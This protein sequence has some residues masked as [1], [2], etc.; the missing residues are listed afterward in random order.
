MRA[1][2]EIGDASNKRFRSDSRTSIWESAVWRR[3]SVFPEFRNFW[4]AKEIRTAGRDKMDN[5]AKTVSPSEPSISNDVNLYLRFLL[6]TRFSYLG[7]VSISLAIM[8]S[9]KEPS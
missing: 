9:K 2:P 8:D 7:P 3:L 6:A 4:G 5:S 1:I